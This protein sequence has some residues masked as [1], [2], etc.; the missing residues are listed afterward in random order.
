MDGDTVCS[1]LHMVDTYFGLTGIINGQ[2]RHK[3]ACLLLIE[4]AENW[5]DR[6][7][8]TSNA[9]LGSLKSDFLSQ[10]KPFDYDRL[11]HEALDWCGQCSSDVSEYIRA[12]RLALFRCDTHV[13]EEESLHRFQQSLWDKDKI[14]VL[15]QCPA[16][17]EATVEIV[18]CEGTILAHTWYGKGL[19]K[20]KNKGKNPYHIPYNCTYV[21]GDAGTVRI[22]LGKITLKYWTWRGPHY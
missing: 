1:F 17:F 16:T 8:Y 3:S 22:E 5:Y 14:Q 20:P 15:V 7:N 6:R 9:T 10:F 11:N 12:F 13:S 21:G 4:D 2:I 18:D 19:K